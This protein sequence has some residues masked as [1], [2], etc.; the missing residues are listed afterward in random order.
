[1]K[2]DEFYEKN[3]YCNGSLTP[4]NLGLGFGKSSRKYGVFS[5]Y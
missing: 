3:G 4:P 2:K 1:M 5:R